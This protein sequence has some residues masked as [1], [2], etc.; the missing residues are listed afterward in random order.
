MTGTFY[1]HKMLA[2]KWI[3]YLDMDQDPTTGTDYAYADGVEHVV[4]SEW[5]DARWKD[6][7]EIT[8]ES[9]AMTVPTASAGGPA[10]IAPTRCN[11]HVSN[12]RSGTHATAFARGNTKTRG[13]R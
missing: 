6:Y 8:C 12:D 9:P 13:R 10:D 11:I 4:S 3:C 7:T 5:I 2:C 1:P